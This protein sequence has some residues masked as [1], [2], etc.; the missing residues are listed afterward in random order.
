MAVSPET[1]Q[2]LSKVAFWALKTEHKEPPYCKA[3]GSIVSE[4]DNLVYISLGHNHEGHGIPQREPVHLLKGKFVPWGCSDRQ[5]RLM[6]SSWRL[7]QAR[8]INYYDPW[9][10]CLTIFQYI[11]FL[12]GHIPWSSCLLLATFS[13]Y[14][15]C[16]LP[17]PPSSQGHHKLLSASCRR[18]VCEVDCGFC[19]QLACEVGT[20]ETR[21]DALSLYSSIALHLYSSIALSL[22]SSI[23]LSLYSSIA[24]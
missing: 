20:L 4:V 18:F 17:I 13:S 16:P 22:Y 8:I 21:T 3:D 1:R 7:P 9:I 10:M 24:L 15:P 23:A 5:Y 2:G 12:L 6:R 11:R 14:A 19:F